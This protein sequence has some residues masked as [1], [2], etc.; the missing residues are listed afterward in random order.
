MNY[1]TPH[2]IPK[3]EILQKIKIVNYPLSVQGLKF[4]KYITTKVLL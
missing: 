4:V 2:Q 1:T 3:Y